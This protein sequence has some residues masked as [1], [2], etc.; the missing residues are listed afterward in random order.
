MNRRFD[1]NAWLDQLINIPVAV[2]LGNGIKLTGLMRGHDVNVLFLSP[3]SGDSE[4]PLQMVYKG[5][6]STVQPLQTRASQPLRQP[7]SMYS[8]KQVR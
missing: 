8:S 4:A 3:E 2:Y 6:C 7:A 5:F 1:E